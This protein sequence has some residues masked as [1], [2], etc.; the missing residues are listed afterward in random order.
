MAWSK[1]HRGKRSILVHVA[2]VG[3]T[4]QLLKDLTDEEIERQLP[5]RRNP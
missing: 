3:T 4:L 2:G 5:R 1:K